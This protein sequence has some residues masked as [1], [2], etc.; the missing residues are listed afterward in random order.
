MPKQFSRESSFSNRVGYT[1]KGSVENAKFYI[2]TSQFESVAGGRN[3][4][5]IVG[6]VTPVDYDDDFK[7]RNTATQIQIPNTKGGYDTIYYINGAYDHD[8]EA[9]KDVEKTGWADEFGDYV[10]GA[11]D[12]TDLQGIIPVMQGFWVKGVKGA[13]AITFGL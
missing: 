1:T 5:D 7:F 3:V 9:N 13:S 12:A 6:G 2:F 8:D 4:Q 11:Y 10:G